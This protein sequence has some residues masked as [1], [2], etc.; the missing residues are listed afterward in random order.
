VGEDAGAPTEG[1]VAQVDISPHSLLYMSRVIAL[2]RMSFDPRAVD[3]IFKRFPSASGAVPA[4][5]YRDHVERL[6]LLEGRGN[7]TADQLVEF[8]K[9]SGLLN[10][11]T[12]GISTREAAGWLGAAIM[13]ARKPGHGNTVTPLLL[14]QVLDAKRYGGNEAQ[15][16]MISRIA[17]AV[18][19]DL[20]V[21]ALKLDLM[22][23]MV[24]SDSADLEHTYDQIFE[25]LTQEGLSVGGHGRWSPPARV[26]ERLARIKAL[27]L[28]LNGQA[29]DIREVRMQATFNE[30]AGGNH[31]VRR[32]EPLLNAVTEYL[33]EAR[34]TSMETRIDRMMEIL[35]EGPGRARATDAES[36]IIQGVL[37]YLRLHKG[38]TSAATIQAIQMVRSSP[39]VQPAPSPATP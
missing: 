7:Y 37:D 13:E 19:N 10:E 26:A 18:G 16:A 11:G 9:V 29:L 35:D 5:L 36:A 28:R 14:R 34:L 21:P 6:N 23:A 1:A 4:P 25:E 32:Y 20:T 38:Y 12:S 27:Y 17:T 30:R 31:V 33:V 2:S 15:R 8:W 3:E 22:A 39:G 24:G